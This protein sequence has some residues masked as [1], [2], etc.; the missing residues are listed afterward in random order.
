[1]TESKTQLKTQS[2]IIIGS[3]KSRCFNDDDDDYND[4]E[5]SWT[6]DIEMII[7]NIRS[8]CV[9]LSEYHK[10]EYIRL[11][12]FLK[13]FRIP[14][15]IL[16]GFNSVISVGLQPYC[17]QKFISVINCILSL[18]CGIITSMELYL[19]IQSSLENELITSKEYHILGLDI[20]KIL[21]LHKDNRNIKGSIFLESVFNTYEKLIEKSS[22]LNKKINDKLLNLDTVIEYNYSSLPNTPPQQNSSRN[23]I[24]SFF[25]I[26]LNKKSNR[27]IPLKE[28]HLLINNINNNNKSYMQKTQ[29]PKKYTASSYLEKL[30]ITNL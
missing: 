26:N 1:M 15:I 30:S 7:N 16:A 8:N 18:I 21:T 14:T 2:K 19:S 22:V 23:N 17:D 20:Y 11:K 28:Q 12:S 5:E 9:I 3:R 24:L 29:P 27:I 6:E 13:Y 4:E 10:D 25:D